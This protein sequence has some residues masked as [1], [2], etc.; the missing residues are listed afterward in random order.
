MQTPDQFLNLQAK[1]RR[2]DVDY[3]RGEAN[4]YSDSSSSGLSDSSDG[5][6]EG[7]EDDD[8]EQEVAEGFDKWGE[9]DADAET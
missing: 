2:N 1:L 4:L 7:E 9:M 3:A 5:E 6:E 8:P